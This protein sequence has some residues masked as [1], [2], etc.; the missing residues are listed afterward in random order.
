MTINKHLRNSISAM[1]H[2]LKVAKKNKQFSLIKELTEEIKK[3]ELV[4]KNKNKTLSKKDIDIIKT[5]GYEV[6][7]MPKKI[8]LPDN[9]YIE[10]AY[11]DSELWAD[12]QQIKYKK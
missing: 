8:T 5:L 4:Y 1:K 7:I 11:N 2:N 9:D 3:I 12:S 6:V 10:N